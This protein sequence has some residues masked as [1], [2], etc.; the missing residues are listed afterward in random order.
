MAVQAHRLYA[1]QAHGPLVG[2]GH[3]FRRDA[4]L[5]RPK[6]GGDL[7]MSLG[8][9]IRVDAEEDLRLQSQSLS[10]YRQVLQLLARVHGHAHARL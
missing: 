10:G 5:G 9:N 6:A 3:L 1:Y 2:L 8:R 7:G 4:E